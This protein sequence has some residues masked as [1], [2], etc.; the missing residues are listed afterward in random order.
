MYE[1]MIGRPPFGHVQGM[2]ILWAHL[3]DD[4]PDPGTLRKGLPPEFSKALLTALEKE[5]DKRPHTAGEYA[6]L[7]AQA[8][9]P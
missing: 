6:R 1:C 7:L 5:G 4:P 9:N 3:Q 8:A 2:R